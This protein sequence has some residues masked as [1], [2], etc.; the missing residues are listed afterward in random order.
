MAA[1]TDLYIASVAHRLIANG[2]APTQANVQRHTSRDW[3]TAK[4]SD[5]AFSRFSARVA[6]EVAAQLQ[7][8]DDLAEA[9]R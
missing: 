2:D 9:L 6:R 4:L 1:L 7:E 3:Q 5:T 8:A